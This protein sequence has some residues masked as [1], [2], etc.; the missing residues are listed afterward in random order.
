MIQTR[1]EPTNIRFK[2]TKAFGNGFDIQKRC[3][4]LGYELFER[5][6]AN[7]PKMWNR[8]WW[9]RKML[10]YFSAHPQLQTQLFR[11]IEAL[12]YMRD[13]ADIADHFKQYLQQGDLKLPLPF[14]MAIAF[15]RHDSAWGRALGA[16]IRMGSFMMA[17]GFMTGTNTT[18]AIDYAQSLRRR[19]MTFTLDVLGEATIGEQQADTAANTYMELI[20]ALGRASQT[21]PHIPLLDATASGPMPR[22]NISVKLTALDPVFDPVDPERAYAVI[23]S[24]LSP[25]LLRARELDVFVNVDMEAF[26]YRDMTLWIFKKLLTER[27]FED[28]PDAGIVVQAYLQDARDDL[29]GLLD[30]VKRRGAGIGI[31][32]VKGAYWDT[33]TTQAIRNRTAIPVWIQKWQSDACYEELTAIMLQH[34]DLIRPAFASHNVRSLAQVMAVAESLDLSPRDYELQMLA[35]MGEPLK[36]AIQEMGR[37]LRVY[38]PYGELIKGMAYLIRRLLENTSNDSF[39]KNRF[40]DRNAYDN[41]LSVPELAGLQDGKPADTTLPTRQY[42]DPFEDCSMIASSVGLN[43]TNA[44]AIG[45]SNAAH[46]EKVAAAIADLRSKTGK[47]RLLNIGGEE[48]RGDKWLTSHDPAYPQQ[49]VARVAT[50]EMAHADQVVAAASKAMPGWRSQ[51]FDVRA[52]VLRRAATSLEERRFEFIAQLVREIGKNPIQADGEVVEAIDY[53]N[54]HAALLERL[55]QRPRRRDV[56]GEENVLV[57]EPCGVCLLIGPWDFPLAMLSA[58]I[59]ASVAMG[60]AAIVKPSSKAPIVAA[61]LM[62][63]LRDS[64]LPDGVVN[65]LPAAGESVGQALVE[66]PD[67]HLVAFCGS[68]PNAVKVA[69][70][71]ARVRPRQGHFKR[72]IIDAGGQNAI[73]VDHD[74]DVDEAVM[75]VLESAFAFGGQKCTACS[76]VIVLADVY[77]EFCRKLAGA[78]EQLEVGDPADVGHSIGPVID[79]QTQERLRT[80]I[81]SQKQSY[82]VLFETDASRI[83]V[84]GYYVAPVIFKD[85]DSD[86]ELAQDEVFGP[87]LAVMKANDFDHAIDLANGSPY[88]LTG[89]IYSRSPA[90]IASARERFRVGNLYINRKI[91]GSQ[92]DVQPYGGRQLSGDGARLGSL[93]YLLQY[94]RP[95]TIS[96]NTLRHGLTKSE[97]QAE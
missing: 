43:F 97:D 70:A 90:H 25:L 83:P 92:V 96:E 48:I 78:A 13:D 47:D 27:E 71:A 63:L 58:M 8:A 69:E 23:R 73:I 24:R 57:Y 44:S 91:T 20:E 11:F 80:L 50:A 93:D 77:E 56:P 59:S 19:G 62:E 95:R 82:P 34:A 42:E 4:A 72:T 89:G 46:R 79:G 26:K 38:C 29:L 68:S 14:Q 32:L 12:P 37:C 28:W 65:Y 88:A 2:Q 85:V 87:V 5:A 36:A 60:N 81:A 76:R 33:E 53:F 74:V 67:V 3:K 1:I 41:L 45:F 52:D 49:V 35:G 54:Y 55:G 66:H 86:S 9:D 30:W 31:R 22:A 40:G 21:W 10:E 51:P 15:K 75:G 61:M 16:N 17:R 7:E 6:H 39:L 18:E 64:R 94:C 84:S